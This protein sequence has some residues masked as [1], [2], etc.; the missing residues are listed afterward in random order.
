MSIYLDHAA[1]TK[2]AEPVVRAIT[3]CLTEHYG[4]PSSLHRVG[5]DAQLVMDSARRTVADA[6][7]ASPQELL[8]TSGATEASNL[9]LRGAAAV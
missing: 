7:G 5:L 4:N 9:A 1:T 3:D 2:P 8:F 6:I